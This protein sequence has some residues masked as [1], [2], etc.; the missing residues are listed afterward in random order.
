M[1]RQQQHSTVRAPSSSAF[2]PFLRS[3]AHIKPIEKANR[4][5][6]I[7]TS[8][9]PKCLHTHR[10]DL[11]SDTPHPHMRVRMNVLPKRASILR[12]TLSLL[13]RPARVSGPLPSTGAEGR[14]VA[15]R[16][17]PPR[18]RPPPTLVMRVLPS[19]PPPSCS[20]RPLTRPPHTPTFIC[21]PAYVAGPQL[22]PTVHGQLLQQRKAGGGRKP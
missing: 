18:C 16:S 20:D 14:G 13:S 3:V 21:V 1:C 8:L 4:A 6:L 9:R 11:S 10:Y 12:P 7:L 22:N 17:S 19:P 2:S 5:L 15:Q